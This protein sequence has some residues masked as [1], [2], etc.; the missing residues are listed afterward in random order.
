MLDHVISTREQL[1][2]DIGNL[3]FILIDIAHI[4]LRSY[5]GKRVEI[6]VGWCAFRKETVMNN[7]FILLS[8]G[9]NKTRTDRGL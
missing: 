9:S 8:V 1:K 6:F 3:D 7:D 2:M 4:T 5:L